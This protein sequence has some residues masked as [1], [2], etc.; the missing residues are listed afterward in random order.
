MKNKHSIKNKILLFSSLMALVAVFVMDMN[1][2][3]A[4][5][6]SFAMGLTTG[7]VK[8]CTATSGGAVRLWLANVADVSSFTID[9][10]TGAYSA[11]TMQSGKVFYKFEFEQDNA[12][13]KWTPAMSD[14]G[15][16][17]ITKSI[18]FYLKY[19]TQ[20]HRNALQ[21]IADASACGMVV[22]IE[23]A[24]G[25]KWVHG[26]SQRFLLDRPM[27]LKGG[28]SNSG[29]VFTDPNGS[30]VI[31]EVIDNEYPRQYTGTVPV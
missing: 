12:L 16:F 31:L 14:S 7:F 5:G 18:E 21:D 4:G 1:P 28:E 24:N 11:C 19:I 20:T 2:I 25:Q 8:S 30:N 29:K 3:H 13:F 17:S 15:S 6:I 27:K 10:G 23:D 26:Y 22:I 9:A